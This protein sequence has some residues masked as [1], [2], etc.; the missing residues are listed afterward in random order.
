MATGNNK[1]SGQR[2]TASKKNNQRNKQVEQHS[3]VYAIVLFALS[4]LFLCI[5]F[6]ST[7]RFGPMRA[8]V[9]GFPFIVSVVFGNV[10][11]L[12][13]ECVRY[14]GTFG[15]PDAVVGIV[16]DAVICPHLLTVVRDEL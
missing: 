9:G 2:T 11:V 5:V 10:R 13:I 16:T 12:D 15:N 14:I 1:K 4:V 6:C 8:V 7:G 3:G